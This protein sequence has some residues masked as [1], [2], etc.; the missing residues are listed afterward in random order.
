MVI[1]KV[2]FT[3]TN[4]ASIDLNKAVFTA[5]ASSAYRCAY[6]CIN[7]TRLQ[8]D[9]FQCYSF[10]FCQDRVSGKKICVFYNASHLTDTSLVI[11]SDNNCN[12]YSSRL[13]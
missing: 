6:T 10:D 1:F 2:Q 9:V 11:Q 4:N 5:E 8:N 3:L 7:S 12:H 13:T